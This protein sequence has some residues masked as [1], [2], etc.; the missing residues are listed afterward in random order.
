[1]VDLGAGNARRW[2]P[3][4]Y[5]FYETQWREQ[6]GA[7]GEPEAVQTRLEEDAE[8][9]ATAFA[10]RGEAAGMREAN[11]RGLTDAARVYLKIRAETEE[12]L[13]ARMARIRA[14][15]VR[16]PSLGDKLAEAFVRARL[17]EVREAG[18][19]GHT[20]PQAVADLPEV[21][22][23]QIPR[24]VPVAGLVLAIVSFVVSVGSA[25]RRSA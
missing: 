18:G 20:P 22:R 5:T 9:I 7:W 21:P 6:R 24:W 16:N 10:E 12:E 11:R 23:K 8:A 3:R 15:L 4:A 14:R 1:M 19:K 13:A 2:N 25:A 17:D